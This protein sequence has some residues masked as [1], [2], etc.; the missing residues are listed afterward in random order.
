MRGYTLQYNRGTNYSVMRRVSLAAK[1]RHVIVM[2]SPS[3]NWFLQTEAEGKTKAGLYYSTE[4]SVLWQY[5][6]SW[7]VCKNEVATGQE[8][9]LI[10]ST[11]RVDRVVTLNIDIDLVDKLGSIT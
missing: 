9:V 6:I 10:L 7:T 2:E 5:F 8:L 3:H 1:L 4:G 11:Y